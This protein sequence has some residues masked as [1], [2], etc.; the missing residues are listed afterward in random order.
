MIFC[1]FCALNPEQRKIML[2]KFHN[3]LNDGGSI[4]LDVHSLNVFNMIEEKAIYE[5]NQLN[6]FW[7]P[8]DYYAFV[9]TFKY[10]NEKVSLD[11]YTIFEDC[12]KRIIYNWLHYF[13]KETIT[14]EFEDNGFGIENIYSDVAGKKFDPKS[15]DIAVVAKKL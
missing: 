1:D 3:F 13:S 15:N 7:S 5:K 9:N 2:G 8:N 14:K 10:E 11:K 12:G 4:L 6:G